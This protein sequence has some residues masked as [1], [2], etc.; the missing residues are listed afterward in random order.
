MIGPLVTTLYSEL[1][2][3]TPGHLSQACFFFPDGSRWQKCN[4]PTQ[5]ECLPNSLFW[6]IRPDIV[7]TG[8]Q[9]HLYWQLWHLK[10]VGLG[11]DMVLLRPA[12]SAGSARGSQGT[13][14]ALTIFQLPIRTAGYALLPYETGPGHIY[15]PGQQWGGVGSGP[16]QQLRPCHHLWWKQRDLVSLGHESRSNTGPW[17][18]SPQCFPHGW[19]SSHRPRATT[20]IVS[21]PLH[22]LRVKHHRMILERPRTPLF[23]W[24]QRGGCGE[25]SGSPCI[26]SKI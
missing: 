9:G 23:W 20:S 25:H 4:Y 7:S 16:N 13:A 12:H 22:L 3:S 18:S 24:P 8:A 6:W 2:Q 17:L 15:H 11:R 1:G 21:S 5:W 14:S 19:N 10:S 26:N